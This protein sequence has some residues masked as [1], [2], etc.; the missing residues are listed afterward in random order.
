LINIQY[1]IFNIQFLIFPSENYQTF[2]KQ[3][4]LKIND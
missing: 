4:S 2:D 1:S 3:L